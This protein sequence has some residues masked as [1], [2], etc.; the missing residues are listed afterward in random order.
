MNPFLQKSIQLANESAY[1]DQLSEIYSITDNPIRPLS[2]EIKEQIRR[3]YESRDSFTLLQTLLSISKTHALPIKDSYLGF[4]KKDTEAFFRNP[5]TIER[6]T[7]RLYCLPIDGLLK[8]C[9]APIESNRQLG[10]KF[11]NWLRETDLGFDVVPIERFIANENDAVLDATDKTMKQ[12]A[13]QSLGYNEQKGLD[14]I[15]RI[16]NQYIIGEAKFLTEIGGHQKTQYEE[17]RN[18]LNVVRVNATPIAILDGVIYLRPRGD[19]RPSE[20]Y[21]EIV[22]GVYQNKPIMSALI[23]KEY[24]HWFKRT[25][26]NG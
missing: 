25:Q 9:E 7:S 16:N 15:A 18:L 14:F 26:C 24:L 5:R 23:L 13:N 2:E 21:D 1:L 6:I 12:F 4:L 22:N 17:A 3:S 11:K 8:A 20:I 10:P 19:N